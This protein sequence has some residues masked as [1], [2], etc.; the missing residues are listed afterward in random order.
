MSKSNFEDFLTT[1]KDTHNFYNNTRLTPRMT[2]ALAKKGQTME[3]LT[4]NIQVQR[5]G[6]NDISDDIKISAQYSSNN[7]KN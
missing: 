1:V 6:W 2:Y 3:S 7:G 5:V 4:F